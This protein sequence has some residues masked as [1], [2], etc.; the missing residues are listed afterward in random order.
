MY[1]YLYPRL[2]GAPELEALNIVK[3]GQLAALHQLGASKHGRATFSAVGGT[4]V[5]EEAL[6]ELQDLIRGIC[7]DYGYPGAM[8]QEAQQSF[9]RVLGTALL[10][11]MRI[12]PGD[13]ANDG[14]WS[15]VSLILVPELGP[16]RFPSR[17]NDRLRGHRRN[18][19]RRLWWRAYTFGPNL[20]FAPE[21]CAPLRE[22]DYFQIEERTN[23]FGDQRVARALQDAIWR[24]EQ[25]NAPI[26]RSILV[27]QLALKM[28][29][30]RSH[31]ALD[32]LSKHELDALFDE[33]VEQVRP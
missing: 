26:S 16:W 28:L 33:L 13:A 3:G 29:A 31:T 24:V 20:T 1:T 9:D 10:E 18:V 6:V 5:R 30:V 15:F 11:K 19:V 22:D 17:H 25:S 2:T 32:A 27:R 7:V 8:G 12:V 14:V 21:G 4:P 23:L